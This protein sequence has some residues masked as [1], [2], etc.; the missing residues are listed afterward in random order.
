MELE[1]LEWTGMQ[2][3]ESQRQTGIV[4]EPQEWTRQTRQQGTNVI[5]NLQVININALSFCKMIWPYILVTFLEI[6]KHLGVRMFVDQV[7]SVVA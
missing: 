3:D 7:V 4:F 1:F 2:F 5:F 6:M